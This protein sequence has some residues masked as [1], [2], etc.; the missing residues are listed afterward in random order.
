VSK[1]LRADLDCNGEDYRTSHLL[2]G[3]VYDEQLQQD[4][5]DAYISRREDEILTCLI[6][7]LFPRRVPRYL[8]F[9]CGTGRVLARVAQYA[10]ESMGIDISPS[11]IEQARVR[12]ATAKLALLDL[13]TTDA[14]LGTFDLITTF[15]FVGNAQDTLREAA[16]A[17]LVR[18]LNRGGRLV[19]DSH[20]NPH[21]LHNLLHP[22]SAEGQDLHFGKLC[23]LLAR[24]GLEVVQTFGVG[25]WIG[26]DSQCTHDVLTS[27]LAR[28][29]D[30]VPVGR[31]PVARLCANVVVV[32]RKVS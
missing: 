14:D 19:L 15:R 5:F 9:A 21:S 18:R 29:L 11:M 7:R 8:D 16:L 4:P 27:R 31:T 12:C 17:G 26:L 2:K 1:R 25:W 24:H 3:S 23:R 13:T 28:V 10:D 32:A 6:P 22:R 20:R 30:A